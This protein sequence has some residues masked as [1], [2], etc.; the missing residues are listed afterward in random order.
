MCHLAARFDEVILFVILL[1]A[2]RPDVESAMFAQ[3]ASELFED[4]GC[5]GRG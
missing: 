1:R 2:W 4:N 5:V 3:G